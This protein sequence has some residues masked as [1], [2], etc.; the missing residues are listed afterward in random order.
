MLALPHALSHRAPPPGH[1]LRNPGS[2]SSRRRLVGR[3][4][5]PADPE[6]DAAHRLPAQPSLPGASSRESSDGPV[7]R[8]RGGGLAPRRHSARL[9]R[10]PGGPRSGIAIG[11]RGL[12][13]PDHRPAGAPADPL[14]QRSLDAGPARARAPRRE[15]AAESG[16]RRK[17][18]DHRHPGARQDGA[19]PL[20]GG[21]DRGMSGRQG[22]P[23]Q[24]LH[25]RGYGRLPRVAPGA[26]GAA[27]AAAGVRGRR[28]ARAHAPGRL[29]ARGR[30]D[31]RVGGRRRS[32]S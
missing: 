20:P 32:D 17:G 1:R 14:H 6:A 15:G 13:A 28:P 3:H 23:R 19:R 2:R 4:P 22:S 31:L 16:L 5:S 8:N 10:G 21:S 11:R 27:R 30:G 29:P 9:E 25:R 26:R 7:G 24:G 12:V 18:R